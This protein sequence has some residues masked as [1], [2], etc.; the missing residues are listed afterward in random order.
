M[1]SNDTSRRELLDACYF[2]DLSK[3]Q[4]AIA[5]GRLTDEDL[6]E[7]LY[8]ATLLARAD[9]VAALFEAGA[10]LTIR[11][12]DALPGRH[13]HQDPRI[14][15]Q[16]LDR[17][18]DPNIRLSNGDP[19]MIL[20]PA[21]AAVLLSAGA[22]PNLRGPRGIPPLARAIASA[23]NPDTSLLELYLA[24]GAT[25]E[26]DLL[27]SAVAPRVQQSEPMTRFLLERGVDPNGTSD[28][29]YP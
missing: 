1:E 9:I 27:F 14:V 24:H 15:R 2:N 13:H 20:N 25:L 11:A 7:G 10:R 28:D 12:A 29:D 19:L 23:R 17:G 21:C 8:F 6:D 26:P 22:D 4:G 5:T 16:F 3:A 18:L